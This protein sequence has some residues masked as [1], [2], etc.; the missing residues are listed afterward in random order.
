[1]DSATGGEDGSVAVLFVDGINGLVEFFPF[2]GVDG[3]E[4]L[5]LAEAFGFEA[6]EEDAGFFVSV[7]LSVEFAEE[8][9]GGG[10]DGKEVVGGVGE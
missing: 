2:L 4:E 8:A 7:A 5:G 9:E 3:G 10:G 1:M 6:E